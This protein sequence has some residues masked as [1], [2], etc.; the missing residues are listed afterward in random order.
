MA[1]H[2]QLI[3]Q[4][5]SLDD[6]EMSFEKAE[7]FRR[8]ALQG[9]RIKELVLNG[10]R[11]D[12]LVT[13]Y[14]SGVISDAAADYAVPESAYF[15]RSRG[16]EIGA[17]SW[18]TIV[19]FARYNLKHADTKIYNIYGLELY[20]GDVVSAVRRVRVIRS[21]SRLAFTDSGEPFED[22]YSRQYKF[23]EK[24]FRSEDVSGVVDTMR[25]IQ[26]RQRVLQKRSRG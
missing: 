3:G 12:I 23:Y 18:S 24:P 20:E 8:A 15:A 14:A 22:T 9:E 10:Q 1:E 17:N 4:R 2:F 6:T 25:R 21:L 16:G 5:V 11:T 19:T 26:A 7:E 13:S